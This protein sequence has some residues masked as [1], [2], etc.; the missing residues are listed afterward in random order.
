MRI[1]ILVC[2]AC[3]QRATPASQPVAVPSDAPL[4]DAPLDRDLPLLAQRSV[5]LYQDVVAAFAVAG[6]DCA[7][8]TARLGELATIHADVV[9][10]NARVAQEGRTAELQVAL[11]PHDDILSSAAKAIMHSPTLASCARDP[12]FG[13]AWESLVSP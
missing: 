11:R 6:E 13:A 9:A 3:S 10:A 8:A 12:A 5:K 1:A 7:I 4:V 2:A